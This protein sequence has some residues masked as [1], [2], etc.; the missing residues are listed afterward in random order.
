MSTVQNCQITM[1]LKHS[2]LQY[3]FI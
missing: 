1:Q 3:C 2:V